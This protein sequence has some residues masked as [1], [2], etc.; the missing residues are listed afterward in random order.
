MYIHL[1]MGRIPNLV[2]KR[3]YTGTK[4]SCFMIIC[5]WFLS[6]FFEPVTLFYTTQ[7]RSVSI[8]TA[9]HLTRALKCRSQSSC[10]KLMKVHVYCMKLILWGDGHQVK[11]RKSTWNCAQI[12]PETC[13]NC[14]R[15][16]L[17]ASAK[18]TM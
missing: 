10:K 15:M 5:T 6:F 8:Q 1:I 16:V 3:Q 9:K 2:M 17:Q 7:D 11:K 12:V 18:I 13:P 14:I 4:L